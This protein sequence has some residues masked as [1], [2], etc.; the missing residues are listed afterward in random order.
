M[1]HDHSNLSETLD[2]ARNEPESDD[3]LYELMRM[4]YTDEIQVLIQV[5][6]NL[7]GTGSRIL[8]EREHGRNS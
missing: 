5:G 1:I 4:H 8:R 6:A 3:D 7:V 2:F